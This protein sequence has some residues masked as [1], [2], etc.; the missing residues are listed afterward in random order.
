M[1]MFS[2][3]S[4]RVLHWSITNFLKPLKLDAPEEPASTAVVVQRPR[5][6]VSKFT[7]MSSMNWNPWLWR[8]TSPG[9]TSRPVASNSSLALAPA[10]AP[11]TGS[12]AAITPSF[13]AMSRSTW[14]RLF[15]GSITVPPRMIVSKV[16]AAAAAVRSVSCSESTS[17]RRMILARWGRGRVWSAQI[18]LLAEL[19]PT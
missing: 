16:G 6:A 2:S 1:E 4:T 14:S 11:P 5:Q 18:E 3:T 12:T 13:T 19:A 17:R 10:S 8:S 7:P 15:A 9:V